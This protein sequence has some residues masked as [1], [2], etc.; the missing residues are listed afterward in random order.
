MRRHFTRALFALIAVVAI[1]CCF[2]TGLVLPAREAAKSMSCGSKLKQIGIGL[3][4]YEYTYRSLP[5][6]VETDTEGKLWRSWRSQIF[7]TFMEIALG[8]VYD[9]GSS[10]DSTKNMR[11]LNGIPIQLGSKD[12]T[13][14][15]SAVNRIPSVFNCPSCRDN[16]REEINYVV[17]TGE[18]TA[19]QKNRSVKLSDITDGLENT[20]LVVES[21]TCLPEWTEPRDLDFDKMSFVI[22]SGNGQSI[23]S[24]HPLGPMVCFA[25][26]GVY[27]VSTSVTPDELRAM[28]TIAGKEDCFRNDL[29]KRRVLIPY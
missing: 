7:P 21:I 29:I 10:W 5:I 6:S 2:Y 9:G 14:Y 17:V 26:L 16:N 3:L 19:F 4:N 20:L 12:G 8:K 13:T 23:S 22:N 15:M 18:L 24:L 27:H 11:L 28:L 1:S 25:D